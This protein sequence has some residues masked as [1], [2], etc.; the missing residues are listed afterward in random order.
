MQVLYLN[1]SVVK[2]YHSNGR[3]QRGAKEPLDEEE[4]GR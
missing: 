4:G 3:K 1:L 2:M